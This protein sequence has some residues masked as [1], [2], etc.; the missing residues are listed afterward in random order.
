MV[1]RVEGRKLHLLTLL[2]LLQPDEDLFN[3][4]YIEIDRILEVAHTKDAETGE[5]GVLPFAFYKACTSFHTWHPVFS[6]RMG[7]QGLTE[8]LTTY[9]VSIIFPPGSDPLPGKMVLSAV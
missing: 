6:C 1:I 2:C 3:P 4:D 5:V 8:W 9:Q 7:F